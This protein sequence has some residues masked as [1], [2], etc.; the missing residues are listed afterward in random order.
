[1]A[2]PKPKKMRFRNGI[3]ADGH[4]YRGDPEGVWRGREGMNPSQVA[5]QDHILLAEGRYVPYRYVPGKEREELKGA[6]GERASSP[7]KPSGLG[8]QRGVVLQPGA[9]AQRLGF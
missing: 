7:S 5:A 2:E 1:M 6:V 3:I 9:S 4:D 8:L